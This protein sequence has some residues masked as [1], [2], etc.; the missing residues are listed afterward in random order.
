MGIENDIV[1]VALQGVELFTGGKGASHVPCITHGILGTAIAEHQVAFGKG[2]LGGMNVQVLS[3]FGQDYG[4]GN[5]SA[6]SY[7]N[8]LQ[9][10]RN[11]EFGSARAG[12][13]YRM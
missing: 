4:K 13:F 2:V 6:T 8:G 7:G 3:I 1:N 10:T 5:I 11:F 12:V 9:F